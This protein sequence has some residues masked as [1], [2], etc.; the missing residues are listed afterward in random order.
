MEQIY[1][2]QL[3]VNGK[4]E[5]V[6]SRRGEA[7]QAI[8]KAAD[9]TPLEVSL[10]SSEGT[11]PG[12]ETEV[13]IEV[14]GLRKGSRNRYRVRLA[15]TED[16]LISTVSRGENRGR[17]L[18]HAAVT[19]WFRTITSFRTTDEIFKTTTRVQLNSDWKRDQLTLVAFVENLRTLE[20]VGAAARELTPS[21]GL[22][23]R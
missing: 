23:K 18:Q 11:D 19:R 10:S 2:P 4:I 21:A 1:T 9:S 20:I 14:A 17:T 22:E 8:A 3:V 6:G 13:A 12:A 5:F 16:N 7:L 15:I